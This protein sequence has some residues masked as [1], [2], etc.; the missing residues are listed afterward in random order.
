MEKDLLSQENGYFSQFIGLDPYNI[1]RKFLAR[2]A[3]CSE[4][5]QLIV[6]ELILPVAFA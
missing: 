1:I 5:Q 2:R 4:E 3:R 6:L